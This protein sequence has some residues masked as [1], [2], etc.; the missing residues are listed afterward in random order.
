MRKGSILIEVTIAFAISVFALGALTQLSTKSV[1][2]SGFSRRQS[3]ATGYA[4]QGQE[5]I[6]NEKDR[7][8]WDAF[9]SAYSGTRCFNGTQLIGG[10]NCQIGTS[11]FSSTIRILFLTVTPVPVGPQIQVANV[12]S[13]VSWTEGG[14]IYNSTQN[15]Q[16]VRY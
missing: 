2:S 6:R 10:S 8:G 11:E 15:T 4:I 14:K 9:K 12:E 3:V 1:S 5:L 13:V 7:L 16:Y